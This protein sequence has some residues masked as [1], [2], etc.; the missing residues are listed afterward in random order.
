MKV[1]NF[2]SDGFVVIQE[3]NEYF[4]LVQGAV[5]TVVAVMQCGIPVARIELLD[6]IT[7]AAVN[8]YSHTAFKPA[9]TLF[10]EFHGS[11]SGV[12]EQASRTWPFTV[13][14]LY[15]LLNL[16]MYAYGD[17]MIVCVS[18]CVCIW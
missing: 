9:P 11:C 3:N 7:L 10:F 4:T 15:R 1:I 5:D 18:V 13:G 14:S 8:A 6:E 16:L 2:D 12:T 17:H